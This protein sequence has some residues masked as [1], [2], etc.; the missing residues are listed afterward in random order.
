M[1]SL[2]QVFQ[3]LNVSQQCFTIALSPL[4]QSICALRSAQPHQHGGTSTLLA[5]SRTTKQTSS[6]IRRTAAVLVTIYHSPLFSSIDHEICTTRNQSP[7]FRAFLVH[8]HIYAPRPCKLPQ[9]FRSI[10][11]NERRFT[12]DLLCLSLSFSMSASRRVTHRL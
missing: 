3:E 10:P 8:F 9:Y 12:A 5:T 11:L 4:V 6:R 1:Y 2:D 7:E